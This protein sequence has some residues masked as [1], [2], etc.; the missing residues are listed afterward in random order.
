MGMRSWGGY[1]IFDIEIVQAG[2]ECYNKSRIRA[3]ERFMT[4]QKSGEKLPIS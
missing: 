3:R 1:K 4:A 2:E